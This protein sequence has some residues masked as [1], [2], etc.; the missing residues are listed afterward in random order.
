MSLYRCLALS[1]RYVEA[2][3]VPLPD[4]LLPDLNDERAS[5]FAVA[6]VLLPLATRPRAMWRCS[7][8]V[9]QVALSDLPM[10]A[11]SQIERWLCISQSHVELRR[12][13]ETRTLGTKRK[14]KLGTAALQSIAY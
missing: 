1:Q 7:A 8:P 9:V 5:P 11:N 10:V 2:N 12:R 13:T 6:A 4:T 3:S 14:A